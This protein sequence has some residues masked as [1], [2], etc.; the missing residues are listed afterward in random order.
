METRM[1]DIPSTQVSLGQKD[2]RKKLAIG[3]TRTYL[4][5]WRWLELDP[6]FKLVVKCSIYISHHCIITYMDL[7]YHEKKKQSRCNT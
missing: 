2:K 1:G 6:R 5:Q 7:H 3:M 4:Q